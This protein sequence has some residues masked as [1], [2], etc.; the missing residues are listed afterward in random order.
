VLAKYAAIVGDGA[1]AAAAAAEPE[2]AAADS[3][4]DA[5]LSDLAKIL[6][7]EAEPQA[8]EA[9]AAES[10][11]AAADAAEPEVAAEPQAVEADAAPDWM[12]PADWFVGKRC[13]TETSFEIDERDGKVYRLHVEFYDPDWDVVGFV[14]V[15]PEQLECWSPEKCEYLGWLHDWKLRPAPEDEVGDE[16]G[17]ASL[18]ALTDGEAVDAGKVPLLALTDG[19]AVDAGKAP[20][21]ALMDGN[22]VDAEDVGHGGFG[23]RQC[24]PPHIS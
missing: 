14:W 16:A 20:L 18:L 22:A 24:A 10:V 8:V 11:V 21:L 2:D 6:A 7:E 17:K 3:V 12:M 1:A 23:N 19:E 15:T 9:V 13:I 4:E 5:A